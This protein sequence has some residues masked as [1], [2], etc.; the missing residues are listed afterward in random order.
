MRIVVGVL[1][2]L[3]LALAALAR[4]R[5]VDRR[6]GR[7]EWRRLAALQPAAPERFASAMVADLPEPARRY[8]DFVIRPGTP[9][10]T[11]AEI[12]MVGS[13]SLGSRQAP[14]WRPM[15]AKQILAAPA[16][17]VW[18]MRTRGGLRVAGSDSGTWTRFR[19]LGLIPV[20][21]VGNDPDHARSAFGR[22]VAEALFWTPAALLPGP[23]VSW[24]PLGPDSARVTLRHGDASQ[25][26]DVTVDAAGRP[27]QVVFER[28]SNANADRRWRLQPFGGRL[29]D[30]REVEGFRLAHR[31]EAGNGFG[32]PE[33]FA[34]Y[35][36]EVTA[37]RFVRPG[38]A[39]R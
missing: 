2:A 7:A 22:L 17:F 36:V 19:V 5:R 18:A 29:S 21:R 25:A 39:A 33:Y 13:F 31:V 12:D 24:E 27:V 11:V 30:F 38:G 8:F 16:G 9:L 23:G 4:L 6:A 20:A 10:R 35:A 3:V 37:I 15:R 26:V 14:A 34:F 1:I 28:W 32:T